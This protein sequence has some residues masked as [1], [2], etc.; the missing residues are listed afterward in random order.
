M[1]AFSYQL[2]SSRNFPPLADTFAM[3]KKHG[4]DQVEGYGALYDSLDGGV[5]AL[6]RDL[7]EAGLTMPSAHFGLAMLEN[8][9]DR[10]LTI[11]GVLG[12]EAIYCPYLEPEERPT[13]AEGWAAFA[14]RLDRAGQPLRDAGLIFGWHNHDFEFRPAE[15]GSIPQEVMLETAPDLSWEADVAWIVRG[16]AEPLIW[17][18]RY[19][20]RISAVH[21]KDIAPA[22]GNADEDGWADV[23][24]GSV[25]WPKLM[26]TLRETPARYFIMEHD[27]PKDDER[28]ASRSI[29]SA[30]T[31]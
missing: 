4:Y 25:D 10:A 24:H 2:Y 6:K 18:E 20:E 23:G 11:A 17:I 30:K 15:D 7:D 27:N 5:E 1:T 16:G 19:G 26:A 22:G 13:D 8:D 28:F 3:L 31:I 14:K 21:I 29:R 9:P 12:L